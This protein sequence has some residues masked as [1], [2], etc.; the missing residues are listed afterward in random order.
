MPD[1]FR[2]AAVH[3][4]DALPAEL[5]GGVVAIGNFDGLHRGH[6]ELVRLTVAGAR[7]RGVPALL[8]TFEPHPRS[9]FRPEAPVFRLTSLAAKARAAGA[10]GV[11]AVVVAPFDRAF[12]EMD[13][14]A[15]TAAVLVGRL[16]AAEVVIGRDFRFGKGRT[17]SAATLAGEGERH[18]FAVTVAD[19]VLSGEGEPVS[20]S[21]IREALSAGDIARANELL[22]HR[23]FVVG[24]VVPGD[25]R[26]RELGFPTANVRLDGDCRLRHG[27]Y[28]VTVTVDGRTFDA[29]ASYGRRPTFDNGAPLLE[30]YLFDFSG[31][32]YGREVIVTFFAWIRPEERFASVADLVAA[33][34]RDAAE[35]RAILAAAGRGSADDAALAAS[36]KGA[37]VVR[38]DGMG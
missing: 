3:D 23:W 12:S 25:R 10:L 34:N 36:Q 20:S 15:F 19:V 33:M 18:G 38:T 14:D 28:A 37:A 6:A 11:D 7:R 22:G 13:A 21:A 5:R 2:P 16:A 27:I 35:A 31:D 24:T 29:V 32:L 17:G 26:G 4:L 9:V 8:L 30:S 1:R